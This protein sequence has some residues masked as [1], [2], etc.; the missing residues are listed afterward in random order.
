MAD[1]IEQCAVPGTVMV[2]HN[3]REKDPMVYQ[4]ELN[5]ARFEGLMRSD[6]RKPKVSKFTYDRISIQSI[7]NS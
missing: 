5:N 2:Y 4:T 3:W 7:K 6:F 1:K